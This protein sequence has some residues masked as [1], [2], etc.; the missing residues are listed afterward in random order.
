MNAVCWMLD[1]GRW[2]IYVA[3]CIPRRGENPLMI[4]DFIGRKQPIVPDNNTRTIHISRSAS[5]RK[6]QV[7][8]ISPEARMN[9]YTCPQATIAGKTP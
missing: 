4:S 3:C 2:M 8:T 9:A 7:V 5:E 6:T 1:V